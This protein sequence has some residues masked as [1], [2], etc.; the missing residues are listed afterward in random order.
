MAQNLRK[1]D[2][3]L[4]QLGFSKFVTNEFGDRVIM[5]EM[6]MFE[7]ARDEMPFWLFSKI[8]ADRAGVSDFCLA[9][10]DLKGFFSTT[11]P[12]NNNR[13][14]N[15]SI[16]NFVPESTKEVI[17]FNH[18]SNAINHVYVDRSLNEEI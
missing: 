4:G 5:H 9:E 13:D 8:T 15:V 2:T 12:E 18:F 10:N 1:I 16:V 17:I 7:T 6:K 11:D 3:L 14:W